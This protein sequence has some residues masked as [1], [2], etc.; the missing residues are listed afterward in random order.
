MVEKSMRKEMDKSVARRNVENN[1]E[2][3]YVSFAGKERCSFVK[4]KI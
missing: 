2:K 1:L 3:E 4:F